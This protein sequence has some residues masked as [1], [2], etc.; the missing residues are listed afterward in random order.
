MQLPVHALHVDVTRSGKEVNDLISKV[1]PTTILSLGVIDGRNIWGNDY[2]KSLETIKHAASHLGEDR[3][4]IA[5]SSSLL[6]VPFS[7]RFEQK[8]N[9]EIK[10]WLAYAEEKLV[11]LAELRLAYEGKSDF[12]TR[13]QELLKARA[14]SPLIHRQQIKS[15]C[16]KI[17][18]SDLKRQ[19][20]YPQRTGC[21][22]KLSVF[23]I[24]P[25]PPSD[26]S[27]KR[28]KCGPPVRNSAKV[29]SARLT[30]TPFW[31][32]KRPVSFT[33]RTKSALM[34]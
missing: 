32:R 13:N 8:L 30:M 29:K 15:R 11:E 21:S 24:C 5:P 3:V 2:Q 9:P 27:L 1:K 25:P 4:W 33:G 28:K 14:V 34:S 20:P 7:L 26:L 12:V 16:E 18:E 22:A 10:S 6:F 23:P 19:N 31:K 17:S